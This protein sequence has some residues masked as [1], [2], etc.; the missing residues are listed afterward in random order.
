[1]F[2]VVPNC[3]GDEIDRLLDA[4]IEKVP[5]AAK[6]REVLRGQLIEYFADH[7]VIPEFSLA[8]NDGAA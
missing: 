2:Y 3:I 5:G 1:M 6:D 7:G 4:E 8:K